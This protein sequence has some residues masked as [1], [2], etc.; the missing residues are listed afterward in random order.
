M[1][2][3]KRGAAERLIRIF[4]GEKIES[5]LLRNFLYDLV[6]RKILAFLGHVTTEI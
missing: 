6:R 1:A 4:C 3:A 2:S 5:R